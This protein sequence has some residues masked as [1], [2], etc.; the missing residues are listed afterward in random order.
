M[1]TGWQVQLT[2][3]EQSRLV[4]VGYWRSPEQTALPDPALHV[5][6]AWDEEE[7]RTTLVY[8]RSAPACM[9]FYGYS[10][11]RLCGRSGSELG[12][13]DLTDGTWIWPEG[14]PHYLEHHGVR[15]PEPFLVHLRATRFRIEA[16][17]VPGET[18]LARLDPRLIRGM[19]RSEEERLIRFRLSRPATPRDLYLGV[20]IDRTLGSF[21]FEVNE[22]ALAAERRRTER[23]L[24]PPAWRRLVRVL[25]GV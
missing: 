5:D 23:F 22:A 16:P 25:L 17:L 3:D 12:D 15:P 4:P 6:I 10:T 21:R 8:L 1:Q 11:C 13:S 2:D 14:L 20:E 7:R 19:V 24:H 9:R 18:T